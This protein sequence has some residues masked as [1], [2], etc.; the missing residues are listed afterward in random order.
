M[1]QLVN[2]EQWEQIGENKKLEAGAY[3]CV[4]TSVEDITE[5]EYLRIEFDIHEGPFKGYYKEIFNTKQRWLGSFIKSYKEKAL[6]YFKSFI[7]AVEKSNQNFVWDWNEKTLLNKLLVINFAEE[8]YQ[9]IDG[10]LYWSIKPQ[11][12]RSIEALR[13]GKIKKLDPVYV[14][15]E[16]H[17][18]QQTKDVK[19]EESDLPF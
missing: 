14:E 10:E 19:I 18:E 2:K 4:I 11:E 16:E 15:I 9:G 3:V 17:F 5:K 6:G 12:F 7:T 13:N 1:K 8:Q